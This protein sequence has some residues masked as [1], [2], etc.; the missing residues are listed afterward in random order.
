VIVAA[1]AHDMDLAQESS[2]GVEVED[3]DAAV[4]LVLGLPSSSAGA[5]PA[6]LRAQ[7]TTMSAGH[8]GAPRRRGGCGGARRACKVGA[9]MSPAPWRP[10]LPRPSSDPS[11]RTTAMTPATASCGGLPHRSSPRQV[12]GTARE[13]VGPPPRPRLQAE[14]E[15]AGF[16]VAATDRDGAVGFT[17]PA[18]GRKTLNGT[19]TRHRV[20]SRSFFRS[21][22]RQSQS[23][24]CVHIQDFTKSIFSLY[25][26]FGK[27]LL[28]PLT[29][30]G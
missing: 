1:A 24:T 6:W 22:S 14:R 19:A 16:G 12:V 25:V 18:A 27:S 21:Q 29:Y 10:A 15:D 2:S 4:R 5:P 13:R 28:Y 23:P 17:G 9:V 20:A 7:A 26:V 30:G 3:V 8:R 11:S